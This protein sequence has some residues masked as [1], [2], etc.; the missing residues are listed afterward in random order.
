M[1]PEEH[2]AQ[3][4]EEAAAT[5]DGAADLHQESANLHEEHAVE[6]AGQPERVRRAQRIGDKERE[7]ASA[8]SLAAASAAAQENG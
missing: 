7:S 4:H 1:T 5:H 3:V 2:A 8:R 6:M